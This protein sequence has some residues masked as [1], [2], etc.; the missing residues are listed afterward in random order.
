MCKEMNMIKKYFCFFV[1]VTACLAMLSFAFNAFADQS[2]EAGLTVQNAAA[3]AGS[4]NTAAE[5]NIT[6]QNTVP[7][8]VSDTVQ[9]NSQDTVQSISQNNSEKTAQETTD[10]TEEEYAEELDIMARSTLRTFIATMGGTIQE[11]YMFLIDTFREQYADIVQLFRD[12]CVF[13]LVPKAPRKEFEIEV[14]GDKLLNLKSTIAT[15]DSIGSLL[16]GW[17]SFPKILELVDEAK[18]IYSL[19]SLKV[20]NPI[21]L[22]IDLNDKSLKRFEYEFDSTHKIIIDRAADSHDADSYQ[23]M[24]EEIVYDY[25]LCALQGTVSSNFYNAVIDAGEN[26]TFAIRLADVFSYDIDFAREIREGDTFSALVEKRYRDG[27]FTGYGRIIAARFVNNDVLYE[28]FLYHDSEE[29]GK[30]SYFDRNGKALQKAFLR[31]PVHFTRI[32]SHFTMARRHPILGVTRAHPAIDY[33]A[34]IGTPVMAVG[35]GTVVRAAYTGGYGHLIQLK[36]KGDL[37]TQ[38]AHLSG[39]AKGIRSG[40]KV[41]QGQVIGYVGSTGLSTGPHLDF[42]IKKNGQ[43]VNP[44]KIIIPSKAPLRSE[45]MEAYI[46]TIQEIEQMTDGTKKLEEFD[47]QK[48]LDGIR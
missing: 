46:D 36:H 40:A 48:W 16:N 33:A 21:S 32:S 29:E 41:V 31:T 20:N 39:Y 43:Y 12:E 23:V 18:D 19:T 42:R 6:A 26:A 5:Q 2:E 38:Y 1:S 11:E 9:N 3:S 4:E 34:P 30:L 45:Q 8:T 22:L 17:I 44:D 27:S 25:Q 47:A 24:V 7:D 15:G 10:I 28:A 37:E 35:D 14:I 13:I